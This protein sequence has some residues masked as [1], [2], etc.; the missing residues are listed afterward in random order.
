MIYFFTLIPYLLGT[1]L[2][3][4]GEILSHGSQGLNELKG[5]ND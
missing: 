2:I 1:V 5:T 3:S 4:L